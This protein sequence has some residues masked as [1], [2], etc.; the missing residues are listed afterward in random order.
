MRFWVLVSILLLL[1]PSCITIPA[2]TFGGLTGSPTITSFS[3]NPT[4]ITPGGVATLTWSVS[5]ATSVSIDQ[6]IGNVAISGTRAVSPSANTVYTLTAGNGATSATATTSVFVTGSSSGTAAPSGS[7][8]PTINS[9][10]TSPPIVSEGGSSTLS[11]NVSNATSIT[12]G[13]GIGPVASSGSLPI[14]PSTSM[15]YT[16][17]AANAAGNATASTTVLVQ[18]SSAVP[19]PIVLSFAA[20]PAGIVS[21]GSSTLTWNIYG[22]TSVSI[23]PGIGNVGPSGSTTVHPGASTTYTLTATNSAGNV[24]ATTDVNVLMLPQLPVIQYF[25]ANPATIVKGS[26][27]TLAWQTTGATQVLLNGSAVS[28]SGAM[29]VSPSA[30][31][32]YTLAVSNAFGNGYKTISVTVLIINPNLFKQLIV[33]LGP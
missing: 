17:T 6:G 19:P 9:F 2:G 30:T 8:L 21:G 33:P 10:V 29:V 18:M 27:S 25:T 20:S 4:S 16:L 31:Q 24:T 26:S 22:A 12:I 14:T 3:A 13:P 1:I 11:W 23:D 7:G 15:N 28:T 32:N 5:G